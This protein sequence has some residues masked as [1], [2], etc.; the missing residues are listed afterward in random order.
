MIGSIEVS[1]SGVGSRFDF[2]DGNK[3][4]K[5]RRS[6]GFSRMIERVSKFNGR[7]KKVGHPGKGIVR[8]RVDYFK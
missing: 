2:S 6:Q 3:W 1:E 7:E 4:L 5:F 8:R